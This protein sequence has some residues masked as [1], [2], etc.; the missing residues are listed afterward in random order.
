MSFLG[1]DNEFEIFSSFELG[2]LSQIIAISW[3]Q[4]SP[5]LIIEPMISVPERYPSAQKI[6]NIYPKSQ[7]NGSKCSTTP[8]AH[9]IQEWSPCFESRLWLWFSHW[10]HHKP[11]WLNLKHRFAHKHWPQKERTWITW[12]WCRTW[13]RMCRHRQWWTSPIYNWEYSIYN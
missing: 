2:G 10:D 5:K 7:L 9:E 8:E 4:T 3:F 11:T 1:W 13:I 12:I 6:H